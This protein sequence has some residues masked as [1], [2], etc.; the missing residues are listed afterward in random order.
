MAARDLKVRYRQTILGIAWAALQPLGLMA[1]FSLILGRLAGVPSEGVPYPLFV[2]CA[3]GVWTY[4]AHSIQAAADSLIEHRAVI[5]KVYF[6]RLLLPLTPVASGL[7]DLAIALGILGGAMAYYGIRPSSA[8]LALPAFAL[9]TAVSGLAGGL[10]L[11]ALNAR[12]RDFRY[13]VPFLLQALF[14]LSP[15]TYPASLIPER[16]RPLYSLNPLA[17]AIEGFRW[18]L[19]GVGEGPGWMS[20]ISG[21]MLLLFLGTG[22]AFFRSIQ[23]TIVDTVYLERNRGPRR[24]AGKAVPSGPSG[25]LSHPS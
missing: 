3:L 13:V 2:L 17:G 19:M 21:A 5:T 12:Y 1:I 7:V 24:G 25:T 23:T 4:F 10:W 8:L 22:L 16:W 20:G 18:S 6:P 11:S 15:I 14:F 9:L